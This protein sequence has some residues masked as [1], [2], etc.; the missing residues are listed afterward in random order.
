MPEQW[1]G[2]EYH[3]RD[4][5]G[6]RAATRRMGLRLMIDITYK[7]VIIDRQN[8]GQ[9]VRQLQWGVPLDVYVT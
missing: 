6:M 5:W 4:T 9:V 8:M 2:A 3:L 7:S 1:T